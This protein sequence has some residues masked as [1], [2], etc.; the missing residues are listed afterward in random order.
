[1]G[2]DKYS[3]S[4]RSVR[5]KALGY[6]TK[7]VAE[8]F[9]NKNL[10]NAMN[11]HGIAIRESRDSD[12]HPNSL[13]IVLGLDV[14][15]SMDDIPAHLVANGLPTIMGNIIEHGFPDPQVLF[16]AVGDHRCD[17]APLQVGQF[18]SG[19]EKLDQWLTDVFL[20]GKGG[21]NGGESYLLAWYFAGHH[22]SIDCFEKRGKKGLLITIG[23][24]PTHRSIPERTMREIMGKGEYGDYTA[25]Y[26]LEKAQ[27][28]YHVYHIHTT[29]TKTGKRP[30]TIEGWKE[31]IGENLIIIEKAD[32]VSKVITDLVLQHTS[33]Q[34]PYAQDEMRKMQSETVIP[35]NI[36][37]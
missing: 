31:L 26:L 34:G 9:K 22:T 2:Y 17:R 32:E 5:A 19:D 28:K 35:T 10:D 8:I 30:E 33:L 3:V 23:D 21:G 13:A 14:T 7:G 20:E 27:E 29:Q 11:P 16:L 4:S 37:L 6:E 1:M 25:E 36:I 15:G 18:E 12:E 24:E